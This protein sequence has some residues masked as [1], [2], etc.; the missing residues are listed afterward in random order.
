MSRSLV[1]CLLRVEAALHLF[2]SFLSLLEFHLPLVALFQKACGV[3]LGVLGNFGVVLQFFVLNSLGGHNF[4][5]SLFALVAELTFLLEHL[6][7]P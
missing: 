1:V 3:V 7:E 5:H 4:G 2:A 6:F